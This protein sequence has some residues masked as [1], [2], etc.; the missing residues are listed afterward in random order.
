MVSPPTSA[1]RSLVRFV[2]GSF[3][4]GGAQRNNKD[5]LSLDD[6]H[7]LQPTT[8]ARRGDHFWHYRYPE[9]N[10]VE[11]RLPTTTRSVTRTAYHKADVRQMLTRTLEGIRKIQAEDEEL[12]AA[13][14]AEKTVE[15][16]EMMKMD[17]DE[18]TKPTTP[19]DEAKKK[20][21]E[22]TARH[23]ITDTDLKAYGIEKLA[24]ATH[25]GGPSFWLGAG[26]QAACM[27]RKD[28]QWGWM[29]EWFAMTD[30]EFS[31]DAFVRLLKKL[32]PGWF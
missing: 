23:P 2:L 11:V 15:V 4:L 14:R 10:V 18:D 27:K 7:S 6:K 13:E 28:V 19:E 16:L 29:R 22:A 17:V 1:P 25:W 21:A 5:I 9:P 12:K 26:A 8:F 20:K 30:G 24:R 32:F 31:A 3:R